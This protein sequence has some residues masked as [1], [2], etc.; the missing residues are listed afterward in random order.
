LSG[1]SER[2]H[3]L[4]RTGQS[5]QHESGQSAVEYVLLLAM[6]FGTFLFAMRG[7]QDRGF[8]KKLVSP[9]TKDFAFAYRYGHKDARGE[10]D[11]GPVNLIL[12]GG[13]RVFI[14]PSKE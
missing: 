4:H 6:V 10:S 7:I 1:N 9:L 11:G 13:S 14:N 2:G 5:R 8:F 12:G 3:S